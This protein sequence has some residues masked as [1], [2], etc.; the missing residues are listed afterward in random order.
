MLPGTNTPSSLVDLSGDQARAALVAAAV[1]AG[2]LFVAVPRPFAWT[3]AAVVGLGLVL[4]SVKGGKIGFRPV[5]E[6]AAGGQMDSTIPQPGGS[7]LELAEHLVKDLIAAGLYEKEAKAMVK[8]WDHAWFGEEGTRLLYLVPRAKTD[9]LMPISIEPR[10][11]ELVRVLVGRH[12]FLTPEQEAT[13]DTQLARLNAA[14]AEVEAA[15]RELSKLGRFSQEARDQSSRRLAEAAARA[16]AA[17]AG[18]GFMRE[19]P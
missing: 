6:L 3:L 12:D 5:G 16:A 13:A 9:E 11:T 14:Q 8:T 2:A 15:Y 7:R 1:V 18:T 10:P 19:L 4:V 17:V